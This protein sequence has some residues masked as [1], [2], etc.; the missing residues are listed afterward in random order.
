[1]EQ[2]RKSM[3]RAGEGDTDHGEQVSNHE[4]IVVNDK[5]AYPAVVQG[6]DAFLPGAISPHA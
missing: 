2:N 4:D 6:R 5:V 1:M 3:F